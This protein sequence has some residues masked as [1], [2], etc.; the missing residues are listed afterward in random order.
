MIPTPLVLAQLVL[1]AYD[2]TLMASGITPDVS[3]LGYMA[4]GALWGVDLN[5]PRCYGFLAAPLDRSPGQVIAL[6]GTEDG[7]EWVTDAQA[8]MVNNPWGPGRIHGGVKSLVESF[9]WGPDR[10]D[11][12]APITA[13][14][15]LGLAGHSLGGMAARQLSQRL[16]HVGT[17]DTWGEARTCD[18]TA[19]QYALSCVSASSRR[20]NALDLVTMVPLWNPANPLQFYHHTADGKQ[21]GQWGANPL[22]AHQMANYLAAEQAL[23]A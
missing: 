13:L 10:S 6:H 5:G 11:L 2:P 19:A 12:F 18:E 14:T 1:R 23:A 15:V 17:V 16:G 4:Q 8:Y 21:I 20:T 7:P 9:G 3:D 22:A